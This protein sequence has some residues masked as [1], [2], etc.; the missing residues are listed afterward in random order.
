MARLVLGNGDTSQEYAND[1]LNLQIG[2]L[3]NGEIDEDWCTDTYAYIFYPP[4]PD[5]GEEPVSYFALGGFGF[6]YSG[7]RLIGGTV[8][9]AGEAED[10]R[11]VYH[12]TELNLSAAQVYQW[13]ASGN[14]T[15]LLNAVLAGD[16]LILGSGNRDRLIGLA[17]ADALYGYGG[18]DWLDGGEGADM[19]FGG[20]GADRLFGGAGNDTFAAANTPTDRDT[21]ND[22]YDGGAGVDW[23][24]Y[25]QAPAGVVVDLAAGTASDGMGGTDTLT[26]VENVR[27]SQQASTLHGDDQNNVLVGF[28]GDDTLGGGGGD[29]QL[30][31]G[32][33]SDTATYARATTGVDVDLQITGAQ[34]TL[35]AGFDTLSSIENL[36]GSNHVD[37]LVGS[38][39]ANRL[40]GGQGGDTLVGMGG[41]DRL[42]GEAGDDFLIGANPDGSIS[43]ADILVGGSGADFY[44]LDAGDRVTE[45]AADDDAVVF[46][47]VHPVGRTMVLTHADGSRE[48]RALDATLTGYTS[49]RLDSVAP[50]TRFDAEIY[51][52]ENGS[53]VIYSRAGQAKTAWD[54]ISY[55]GEATRDLINGRLDAMLQSNIDYLYGQVSDA[56]EDAGLLFGTPSKPDDDGG[57][58]AIPVLAIAAFELTLAIAI[59][60]YAD[61]KFNQ[62]KLVEGIGSTLR[63]VGEAAGDVLSLLTVEG[64]VNTAIDQ[65]DPNRWDPYADA[66]GNNRGENAPL[67]LAAEGGFGPVQAGA[68]ILDFLAADNAETFRRVFEEQAALDMQRLRDAIEGREHQRDDP[69]GDERLF[70]G[71]GR[72][73]DAGGGDDATVYVTFGVRGA[74]PE[75]LA[76]PGEEPQ[77]AGDGDNTLNGGTGVDTLI[78][79][80]DT[81]GV[82]VQLDL[83]GGNG[84]AT[85]AAIGTDTILNFENVWGGSGNDVLR[86][87]NADN[88]LLGGAGDDRIIYYGAGHD[89]IDGGT[90]IDTADFRGNVGVT[91][92]LMD[93]S[94][95]S[96]LNGALANLTLISIE[97]LI[98][99]SLADNLYGN[100]VD[101]LFM[102]VEWA[103]GQARTDRQDL[104][105]G[106]GGSD[107]LSFADRDGPMQ[108]DGLFAY[109]LDN[110]PGGLVIGATRMI[111]IE[112]WIGSRFGD[113]L[114]GTNDANRIDGAA[115]DDSLRG[116]GGDDVLI[117]GDGVDQFDGGDGWDIAV[118]GGTAAVTLDLNAPRDSSGWATWGSERFR[119]IEAVVGGSGADRFTGTSGDDY[120][121]GA[122]GANIINGGG[123]NDRLFGSGA[124]NGGD[125]ADVIQGA[126][127]G[128]GTIHGDAGDDVIFG[129]GNLFGD[130]GNDRIDGAAGA[131]VL[132]GG[133][134][135]DILRGGAGD[136]SLWSGLGADRLEGGDGRDSVVFLAAGAGVTVNLAAGT[137]IGSDGATDILVSIENSGGTGGNDSLTGS[138]EAN[139]L[140]GGSGGN[141]T[142]SG[143]AGDDTMTGGAGADTLIG[144]DGMDTAVFTGLRSAY[145]I[146]TTGGVTTVSGPDGVDTLTGVERL[147]FSNGFFTPT[148]AP[149]PTTINGTAGADVLNGTTGANTINAGAGDD[150]ITGLAGDDAI[151]GGEGT[152]TAIFSGVRA[153]YTISTA[154]GT[155]TVIGPDGTDT[156]TTVERLQFSDQT[157]IVGAG[158]GQFFAGTGGGD[159]I[160]G[161]SFGDEIQAGA[162]D[163]SITG[164]TGNDAIA[165]GDGTDTAVFQGPRSG[166]AI[167]TTG[168]TTTVIG[169]DG[170]DRLTGVERLQFADGLYSLDGVPLVTTLNGTA[171]QDTLAGD[172]NRNAINGLEGDDALGGAG[173]DDTLNGGAGNDRLNGGAGDDV[174][175]GGDGID[176]AD[177]SDAASGVMVQLAASGGQNTIGSGRDTLSGIEN[178]TGSA[179][180]DYFTGDAGNNVLSDTLGGNDRFIGGAGNDTLSI[181]RSGNGAATDVTLTGGIGDD[182]MTFDGNGRYTDTVVFEGQDGN[183]VISALGAFRANVNGGAGNDR[184]T[185]DTLGGSFVV[186]LGSGSDT[187]ILADTD[188]GFAGSAANLVRDFVAGAG[189]DVLDL[190]AYLAGGALTNFTGGSNPFLDGHMRL[191]QAGADTLVQVDR[192]GGSNGFVTVLTLQKTLASNFTAYNFNGLAPLPAPVEGGAGAD[193]LTG[194]SGIDVLNGNGGND[195]LVGL[196]GADVLN[197][198]AGND[199]LDGGA[200]D[201]VLNGGSGGLGDTATYATASAGVN[202]NLGVLGLQ[203]TGGSGFDSLTGIEHLVGSAFTDEL[204]GDGF[205]NQLTDTLGG[206]DFLRGEAGNDTLLV[207]RSG[208]GAATTVRLN[209]GADND[210]LTFTGNGRFTDTVTLEGEAGND[211]ITVSGALTIGIDAG[212]GDDT[213]LYDT[214]G[215][216]HRMTLGTGVDTVRLAGTGGLFQASGDNLV[217]D[218]TTGAGGD[219]VDLSAYIAGG[220]L[221]NYTGGDNPFADGHMRLVQSGTRTLLQVDRDGGGN[222][223][224]TVLAFANTTV[225]SFTTANFNGFDPTGAV[226]APLE[227]ADKDAGPQVLPQAGDD[228]LVLPGVAELKLNEDGPQVL[229]GVFDDS[230]PVKAGLFDFDRT[231]PFDL[232][233]GEDGVVSNGWDHRDHGQDGWQ[234]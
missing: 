196:A 132:D 217:R 48:I 52:G 74:P 142:L 131:D 118:I 99:T 43:G 100:D 152:D 18:D 110:Q 96:A 122:A 50:N 6:T 139:T 121:D 147:Q 136:D 9:Q 127:T 80:A 25:S 208:G 57:Q 44:V 109:R 231:A 213:V 156:L 82:D 169:P 41:A 224:Q 20:A 17:G 225:A 191:V 97:N 137:A 49:A 150:F 105:D 68:D 46:Q 141:D 229:P 30:L 119:S 233:I 66:A 218:F 40:Q 154:G 88:Q 125:G 73:I 160:T 161:T 226:P 151:D 171:G 182:T 14:S 98:G 146:A 230:L 202:V 181:E 90:G 53:G 101:N 145:V 148:G 16:D 33:G 94:R 70:L 112:N 28:G 87:N 205:N 38:A 219:I 29:D 63:A 232:I 42:E 223:Y 172:V 93:S 165:G 167:S 56:F 138:A 102:T 170:T 1:M 176:T 124:L 3:L 45:F 187:L 194:T 186:K 193:S 135:A 32:L 111:S 117:G 83:N 35:G 168:G 86:G 107:T 159:T 179:F 153:S 164:G 227:A 134:G 162:G 15:A 78:Y 123:G 12:I 234:F 4:Y 19:L 54:A 71:G 190:S 59:I 106:R 143:L 91:I 216:V 47:T 67:A 206:N 8:T 215:G 133:E 199:V 189:G 183:D 37:S 23:V 198:G 185:V 184:V 51:N 11:L 220:A 60:Y 26:G 173:G 39:A 34:N 76:A 5:P 200:G 115:G 79:T 192:D 203:N 108:S 214:L 114:S 2:T 212:A 21:G 221:T 104:V 10:G 210:A 85:G 77:G 222:G 31:G 228:F 126:S 84:R 36:V 69:N 177:Y 178:L 155:T 158:G 120:L 211:V 64:R 209:G 13:I 103:S 140:H 195:S 24:D 180:R 129:S 144:G 22:T 174:L 55:D 201:D 149:F 207:T 204:R 113:S 65:G 166:Y 81:Q 175:N 75:S 62:G 72:N 197:G 58:A 7:T 163:D 188:G 157:L 27:G 92:D 128:T 61:K 130:A 95:N 116:H 89:V